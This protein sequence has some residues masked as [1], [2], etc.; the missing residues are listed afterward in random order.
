MAAFAKWAVEKRR[1]DEAHEAEGQRIRAMRR[2][3]ECLS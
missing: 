3:E 2:V 1:A